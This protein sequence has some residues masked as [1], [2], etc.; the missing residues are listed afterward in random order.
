M[1]G[2]TLPTQ[3]QN[4][5]R[6]LRSGLRQDSTRR[7]CCVVQ[8]ELAPPASSMNIVPTGPAHRPSTLPS[9]PF[10]HVG[11]ESG[12]WEYVAPRVFDPLIEE[13]ATD[14][15]ARCCQ[16]TTRLWPSAVR[17]RLRSRCVMAPNQQAV[18]FAHHTTSEAGGVSKTSPSLTTITGT[19]SDADKIGVPSMDLSLAFMHHPNLR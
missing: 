1:A 18:S 10:C 9:E 13:V 4:A 2:A 17:T 12:F 14:D 5:S 3:R 19:I 8:C 11:V 16:Q 6:P 15:A 7:R